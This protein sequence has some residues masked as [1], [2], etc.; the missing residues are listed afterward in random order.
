[1]KRLMLSLVFAFGAT[2]SMAKA[3]PPLSQQSEI[4]EGLLAVGIADEIRKQ[5]ASISPRYVKVLTFMSSL[6][7]KA[8]D[9]GYTDQQIKAYVTSK[10]EKAKMR[11]K[12]EAYLVDAGVKKGDAES[13]CTVGREEVA[14]R[15]LIGSFLRV[16]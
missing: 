9:L 11:A 7:D 6:E 1:M 15:S 8:R 2:A 14:K 10:A 12:G 4:N 3:L 13:Y 16:R 5:C